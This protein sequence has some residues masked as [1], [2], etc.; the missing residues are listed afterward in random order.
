MKGIILAGGK[1]TRLYPSTIAVSKQLLPVYDKPMIYYPLSVLLM[2]EIK[3]ILIISTKKDITNYRYLLGDGKKLG[4][5]IS[6]SVQKEARGIVDGFIIGKQFIGK[7]NVCLILGD[8]IFYGDDLSKILNKAKIE[9]EGATIFG[10]RVK[11]PENFG[12]VQLDASGKVVSIEEKPK[13]PQS[14][15]AV[16]GLYFY[17]N[18]VIKISKQIEMSERKEL[19]ITSLNNEY[20]KNDNLKIQILDED[21]F[22]IDAGTSNNLLEVS[23]FVKNFQLKQKKYIACIEEISWKNGFIN[24]KQLK[25]EAEKLSCTDYGKY[26]FSILEGDSSE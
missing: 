16:P 15:Y 1:G 7:D 24:N 2:L 12:V 23:N 17:N 11:K 6:Y 19:E 9:N 13:N 8:N 21:N 5:N 14:N 18:D 25:K 3:D 4:I 22:W 20:L 10:Y 26:I